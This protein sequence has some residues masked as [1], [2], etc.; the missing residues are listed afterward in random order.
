MGDPH[1]EI[2]KNVKLSEEQFILENQSEARL[3][4]HFEQSKLKDH[5]IIK[6]G[7]ISTLIK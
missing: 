4:K 3:E 1:I 6:D 2:Y 7:K 5:V